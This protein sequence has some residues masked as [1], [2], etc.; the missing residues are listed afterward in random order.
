MHG[1]AVIGACLAVVFALLAGERIA[2][3]RWRRRVPLRIAVLG[4]RGKSSVTR[5]VAHGLR[6]GDRRVLYKTTGSLPVQGAV[7]GKERIVRRN[8]L[9]SPLEQRRV[10]RGAARQCADAVVVEAMSIRR[11]SLRS[12]VRT[13]LDPHLVVITNVGADHVNDLP[14]PVAAFAEAAPRGATAI[15]PDTV[16][17][18]LT[19]ALARRGVRLL[20]VTTPSASADAPMPCLGHAEW[21]ENV[22]L[23]L[24]ACEVAGVPREVSRRGMGDAVP[25]VGALAA[26][27][28]DV[29]GTKCIAVNGFAANDPVA[30]WRGLHRAIARWN[31]PGGVMVGILNLRRDRGDRTHQWMESL[32]RDAWPLDV[33]IV[34]GDVPLSV[35]R[36]LRLRARM[37]TVF[38]RSSSTKR[39]MLVAVAEAAKR[40]E[41]AMLFGMGNIRGPAMR[42]VESWKAGGEQL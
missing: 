35:R 40:G 30:T 19:K 21:S 26:W 31:A 32:R 36:R 29:D 38:P 10:L 11:E 3:S 18:S 16:P 12:E 2:L 23:A 39:L 15:V 5:L 22:A 13:I 14:D 42:L 7:D 8:G 6:E 34:I 33:V 17:P 41:N 24:A 37:D 27:R 4:T 1:Y 25:D 28:L 9:P 20:R